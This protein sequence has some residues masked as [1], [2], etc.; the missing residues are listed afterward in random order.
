VLWPDSDVSGGDR[1]RPSSGE[2][3]CP[4]S[5]LVK[6]ARS[7]SMSMDRDAVAISAAALS[8]MPVSDEQ[9]DIMSIRSLLTSVYSPAHLFGSSRGFP[10][11]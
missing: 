3:S 7:A 10:D 8:G 5:M 2:P 6:R 4:P 1:K 11:R 9:P